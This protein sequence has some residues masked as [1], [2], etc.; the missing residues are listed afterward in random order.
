M[1]SGEE[2]LLGG[3]YLLTEVVGEG[4]LGRVW[5]GHDEL[6]DRAVAVKEI[7]LPPHSPAGTRQSH[8][9]RL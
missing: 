8:E 5:R 2:L 3:R 1:P 7:R 9:L 4:G 6:L